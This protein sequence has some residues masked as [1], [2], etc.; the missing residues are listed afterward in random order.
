M[1]DD[2]LASRVA[3]AHALAASHQSLVAQDLAA[4][5]ADQEADRL[6][7]TRERDES[8]TEADTLRSSLW[9]LVAAIGITM[10]RSEWRPDVP[11]LI[12]AVCRDL[13]RAWDMVVSLRKEL[14]EA[15]AEAARLRTAPPIF[16]A[17][18]LSSRTEGRVTIHRACTLP[19]GYPGDC[20]EAIGAG[21]PTTTDKEG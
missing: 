5:V 3:A 4:L 9:P 6:R 17:R 18:V 16:C 15:R 7:L 13:K 12:E 21:E 2:T 10:D 20:S 19:A 8:R 11:L 1:S 14:D